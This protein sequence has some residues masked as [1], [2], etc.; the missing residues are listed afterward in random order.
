MSRRY[1]FLETLY[2]FLILGGERFLKIPGEVFLEGFSSTILSG[3]GMLGSRGR[4][5]KDSTPIIIGQLLGDCALGPR[6]EMIWPVT[7][8][9]SL[10]L[11]CDW[12]A[13]IFPVRVHG[14]RIA[15]LRT[16]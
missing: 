5:E 1:E 3:L 12:E 7:K 6:T 15:W 16:S 13:Y 8:G 11:E 10:L 9:Y 4:I 14:W 2:P